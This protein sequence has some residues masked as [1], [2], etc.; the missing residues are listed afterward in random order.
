MKILLAID[1][2]ECSAQALETLRS[3]PWP[4]PLSITVLTALEFHPDLAVPEG[5]P[6]YSDSY[7]TL[8]ARTRSEAEQLVAEA[9]ARLVASLPAAEVTARVV[10][11]PAAHAILSQLADNPA[12]LV[13]LGSHGR[14]VFAR[15][16]L[17]SVS[18][19]VARHARCS[20]EVVKS[21]TA[22]AT[23]FRV[24]LPMD[25]SAPASRAVERVKALPWPTATEMRLVA[26]I[27]PLEFLSA[28]EIGGHEVLFELEQAKAARRSTEAKL[29]ELRDELAASGRVSV[30]CEVID[31]DPR[32]VIVNL[33]TQWPASLSLLG[34][35]GRTGLQHLLLGSVADAVLHAAP[36]SVHIVK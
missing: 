7:E 9:R 5:L 33:A 35:H 20:V 3:R 12:D 29:R 1:G 2:S 15:L 23:G 17:G 26:A 30:S 28:S 11:G 6:I 31:G 19:K 13:I 14:G 10:A 16:M 25:F 34:S 8:L 36:C 27:P 32:E 21:A 22:E 24:L 4:T 18:N